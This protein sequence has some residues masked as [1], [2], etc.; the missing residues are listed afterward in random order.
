MEYT[1]ARIKAS[2]ILEG[3]HGDDADTRLFSA[4][5]GFKIDPSWSLLARS[6]MSAS[7]G[8]GA[9]AGN[10]HHLARHQIG[11][12]YRPVDTDSWNALMRY[13]R[14]SERVTGTGSS[15]GALDGASVFGAGNG[16][17]AL[18]GRTS[19]DIVSAH[20]NYNPRPGTM[21]NGRYAAKWSRADDGLLRSTYWAHLLQA[22]YT[23]DLNDSWDLGVQAGLLRGKGGGL[24]KTLGIEVGYQVMKDL[25]VSAGYNFVGLKDRD[26]AANDYT[27]KGAYI[28]LRFK[29]DETA[30][31]AASAGA[32]APV[33]DERTDR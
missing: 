8:Q 3:R 22:R 12:A 6:V 28:R 13:E 16:S 20:L 18:P 5:F 27:S 17:A 24:Q 21:I 26:L 11:L 32:A 9:N 14:R 10:A 23:Q 30:L 25:W 1:D 31:G 7:E 19:A 29:F 33:K 15:T 4:G 2:G